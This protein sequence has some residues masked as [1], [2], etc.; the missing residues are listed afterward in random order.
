MKTRIWVLT[1]ILLIASMS[2][3]ACEIKKADTGAVA[4]SDMKERSCS[5]GGC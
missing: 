3:A 1:I 2:L 5:W 4:R